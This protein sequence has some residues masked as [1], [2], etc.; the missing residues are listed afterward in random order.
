M[1]PVNPQ[2][3]LNW[4]WPFLKWPFKNDHQ[5]CQQRNWAYNFCVC[6]CVFLG[7][8][9]S[10]TISQGQDLPLAM[11]RSLLLKAPS[12]EVLPPEDFSVKFN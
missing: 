9:N 6:V 10:P 5:I 1:H 7:R 8:K 12:W 11:K 4:N 2:G 3:T